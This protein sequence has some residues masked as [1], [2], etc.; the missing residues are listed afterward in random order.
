M[1]QQ[2]PLPHGGWDTWLR[3][4]RRQDFSMGKGSSRKLPYELQEYTDLVEEF[5]KCFKFCMLILGIVPS[6]SVCWLK[7]NPRGIVEFF[8][9]K[10][11]LCTVAVSL[12][13]GSKERC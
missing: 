10:Y 3:H 13:R 2:I 7:K 11:A 9:H 1:K 5:V 8:I 12:L 6:F 4:R